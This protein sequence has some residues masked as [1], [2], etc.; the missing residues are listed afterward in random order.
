MEI[1][2]HN[3]FIITDHK[4]KTIEKDGYKIQVIPVWEWLTR[5]DF[6]QQFACFLP[7]ISQI[8]Q[9]YFRNN[10]NHI[11]FKVGNDAYLGSSS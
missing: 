7:R 8:T 11:Y 9:I 2:N 5:D 3:I 6:L 10:L 1:R 4:N